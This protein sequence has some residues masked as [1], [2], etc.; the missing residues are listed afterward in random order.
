MA[1]PAVIGRIESAAL[2][3]LVDDQQGWSGIA[4]DALDEP[5][6]ALGPAEGLDDLGERGAVDAPC[7]ADRRHAQG[8]GEVALAG[9]GR[10]QEVHDLGPGDEV[11]LGEGQDP[12]AIE[13][14]L[15]GEVEALERLGRR[16]AG[17]LERHGDAAALA[18]GMLLGQQAVDGLKG[19]ELAALDPAHGVVEGLQRPG[20]AQADQAGAD[21]VQGLAHDAARSPARRR[22]TAS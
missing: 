18:G 14:G 19:G 16:E 8:G 9:A 21:A 12:A 22:A 1:P 7:G 11:E 4:A 20:H 17:G 5:A 10:A 13:G 3:G 2:D 6:L 15:E